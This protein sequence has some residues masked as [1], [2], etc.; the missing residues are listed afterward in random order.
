MGRAVREAGMYIVP[1]S[2]KVSS[3]PPFSQ[4]PYQPSNNEKLRFYG[5]FKQAT[6]GKNDTKRPGMLDFIGKAKW[7]AWEALG[8]MSSEEAMQQYVDEYEKMEDKMRDLGLV[9]Q[10]HPQQ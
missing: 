3:L 7:D 10:D 5:L 4:G 2:N 1:H 6:V 8:D 9:P